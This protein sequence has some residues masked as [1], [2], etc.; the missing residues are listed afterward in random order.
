MKCSHCQFENPPATTVC[1]GCGAAVPP[2][3]DAKASYA[4]AAVSGN[5]LL[6]NEEELRAKA[7]WLAKRIQAKRAFAGR[8]S[9]IS[10]TARTPLPSISKIETEMSLIL[11]GIFVGAIALS[12]TTIYFSMP[13]H[14]A[15]AVR[16]RVA[17]F[18]SD[19]RKEAVR[20]ANADTRPEAVASTQAA[21]QVESGPQ[22]EVAPAAT[23]VQV[24]DLEPI[25]ADGV[26]MA[27]PP[28]E[29]E[30]VL[31]NTSPAVIPA[32]A[33]SAS[34]ANS[35]RNSSKSVH[36]KHIPKH[37]ARQLAAACMPAHQGKCHPQYVVSFK[38]F[39]GPVLEERVYPNRKMTR[40]ARTLWDREGKILEADGTINDKYVVKPKTFAPI[41]GFPVS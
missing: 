22:P 27:A 12:F 2:H 25:P 11:G 3:P 19:A 21:L 35:A 4:S 29:P 17:G 33:E 32:K 10:N 6:G 8:L 7:E 28:S 31:Q 30:M 41:P 34:T 20:E 23:T 18:V 26:T 39:W 36:S 24:A 40:R 37:R 9:A 14:E 1:A 13:G 15:E 16:G 38:R 5:L